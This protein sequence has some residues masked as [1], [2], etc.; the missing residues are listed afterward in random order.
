MKARKDIAKIYFLISVSIFV[1]FPL[2]FL[3]SIIG[4]LPFP[5]VIYFIHLG[6]LILSTPLLFLCG[7][8][9]VFILPKTTKRYFLYGGMFI[10]SLLF[11]LLS[12]ALIPIY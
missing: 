7:L 4:N 12:L 9:L 6:F 8:A 3:E 2:L 11:A 1:S 5:L 10:N